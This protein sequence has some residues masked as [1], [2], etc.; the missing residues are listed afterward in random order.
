MNS[1]PIILHV[2][3]EWD[4]QFMLQR[5]LKKEA[6][7]LDLR[8][9]NHGDEAVEYLSGKGKFAD[10]GAYPLPA[11]ILM[12]I[13]M[14]RRSGLEVLQ[15]LRNDSGCKGIPV[16]MVSSSPLQADMNRAYEL[17]VNAYLIKPLAYLQVAEMLRTNPHL[18]EHHPTKSP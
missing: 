4:D 16:I 5:T 2:E 1:R 15:W 17:G 6:V 3:D 14:P 9:A 7:D 8:V 10:R 13:K 18:F 11:L 12:D